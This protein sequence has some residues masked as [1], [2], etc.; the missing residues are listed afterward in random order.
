MRDKLK[1]MKFGFN[2]CGKMTNA[3]YC[4]IVACNYLIKR[5]KIIVIFNILC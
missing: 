2:P 1:V 4:T 3:I 5:T